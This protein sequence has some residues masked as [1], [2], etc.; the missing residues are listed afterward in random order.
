MESTIK[1][2][3]EAHRDGKFED[4]KKIYQ[5][6]L[7]INPNMPEIHNNLALVMVKFGKLI[8]AEASLKKAIEIKP[9]FVDAHYNLGTLLLTLNKLDEAEIRFEKVINIKPNH[10]NAVFNL[11]ET[12]LKKKKLKDAEE[13]F[14]KTIEYQPNHGLAYNRLG[15]IYFAAGKLKDSE[16]FYKEAIKL[17][18]NYAKA[19]CD[20]G[21][22]QK[23][24]GKMNEALSS[25]LNATRL[26][27]NYKEA[28]YGLGIIYYEN[29]NLENATEHFKLADD[30]LDSQNYVLK[31]YYITNEKDNFHTQL[32]K[33]IDQGLNN[34]VMGSLIISSEIKFGIKRKNIFCKYPM[35]YVVTN[36]LTKDYDFENIFVVTAKNILK[37]QDFKNQ[38]LLTNGQQSSGNFFHLENN[39]VKE[40][41]NI[42]IIEI[43]KYR[44]LFKN[45]EEGF[46]KNWPTKF[47]L[48][49]WFI[50]MKSGGSLKSHMH[51]SGWLSGSVYINIPK[52]NKKDSGNLVLNNGIKEEE[53]SIDIRTGN[54]CL[55]PASLHHYTIPFESEDD[56]VVLAFDVKP[57]K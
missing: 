40:I 9:D 10:I 37:K 7:E 38:P 49:G 15:S 12:L 3:I 30:Y 29:N 8:D 55:F 19:H 52:K 27:K 6:I 18:S 39:V 33:M 36:D 31:R 47:E 24:M 46:I 51:E 57:K 5:K 2:A 26:K 22:L 44:E 14:K 53:K 28:H 16:I 43:E 1:Q 42:L 48:N 17:N 25:Y 56:R 21:I 20:L 41:K 50:S 4:A 23:E 32:D 54:L 45:S 13:L 34:A 35:K 11:G